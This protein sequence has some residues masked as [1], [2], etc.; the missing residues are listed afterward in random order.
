MQFHP[1]HPM[2]IA[3]NVIQGQATFPD[4][5]S[6]PAI[7]RET[8]ITIAMDDSLKARPRSRAVTVLADLD[9]EHAS[10]TCDFLLETSKSSL[11]RQAATTK[12]RP[13]HLLL[14]RLQYDPSYVV[15]IKALEYLPES[16]PINDLRI[17]ANDPHWR[18]RD[19]LLQIIESRDLLKEVSGW[20]ATEREI[21]FVEFA[22]W[23]ESRARLPELTSTEQTFGW[24]SDPA[25]LVARLKTLPRKKWLEQ[26]PHLI[27]HDAERVRSWAV[28]Q[29]LEFGT[30]ELCATAAELAEDPR[31]PGWWSVESVVMRLP[32][33][34]RPSWKPIE[35][36][37][38]EWSQAHPLR[39]EVD[40]PA[41]ESC[42]LV[43][44][45]YLEQRGMWPEQILPAAPR[46]S[47]SKPP[48]TISL[49]E[50]EPKQKR[51]AVSGHYLLPTEQF[52][53]AFDSGI[54]HFFWESNY[55]TFN[56][57]VARLA[58]HH[59]HRLNMICGTFEA[60]PRKIVKDVERALRI[61]KLEQLD[62]F[63]LFWTRSQLRLDGA[64][65]SALERL[66]SDGKVGSFGLSTHQWQLAR[67]QINAGFNL[68]MVRHNLAHRS[69][70]EIVFP[71]ARTAKTRII[72]FNTTCYGR[73]LKAGISARDCIRYSLTQRDID[74]VL[75]AP[76]NAEQLRENL[77]ALDMTPPTK[78]E[79]EQWREVGD[80][81][82]AD[83]KAFQ[84]GLQSR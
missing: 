52:A 7:Q 69:A 35:P 3:W 30:R 56:R 71:V 24:D 55:G 45:R 25:V 38:H 61:L 12:C 1:T 32:N 79:I 31:H 58:P 64:T 18:V 20:T 81:V 27:H 17:A 70:E 72:S 11:V 84:N 15:R 43:L 40:D 78:D 67:D 51:L 10:E 26:L 83:N 4:L 63:L 42:W 77:S 33:S 44:N 65:L 47:L 16:T 62:T 6:W 37:G 5:D 80:R 59:R 73:L 75:T 54:D 41:Q 82:Y 60:E 21:G 66:K 2:T 13:S 29:L 76:A 36:L 68:V 14:R 8:A 48:S 23:R 9:D 22:N 57:F 39:R 50:R 46:P 19:A 28:G 53:V 34:R 49:S 74:L